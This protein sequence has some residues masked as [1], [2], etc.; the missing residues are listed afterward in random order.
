MSAPVWSI[1]CRRSARRGRSRRGCAD[2]RPRRGRRAPG[3]ATVSCLGAGDL[4]RREALLF[5]CAMR[6]IAGLLVRLSMARTSIT[7]DTSRPRHPLGRMSQKTRSAIIGLG[8]WG[9]KVAQELSAA[10]DLVAFA[11]RTA[12]SG[13]LWAAEH[14]PGA[15]RATVDQIMH[16]NSIQALAIV[17]PIPLLSTLAHSALAAGKH[18]HVE[19]PLAQSSQEAEVLANLAARRGLILSTGYVFLYHPVYSE[20]K[21]RVELNSIRNIKLEWRKFGTFA[22]PIEHSLL[23]HHLALML[24]L[25]GEP[26]AG[27]I[28]HGPGRYTSCDRIETHLEYPAFDAASIIDRTSSRRAHRTTIETDTGSSLV[29]ED[30]VLSSVDKNGTPTMLYDDKRPALAAEIARFAD[31]AAGGDAV[32]PTAGLFA[33]SVLRLQERLRE[34]K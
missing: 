21:R 14:L 1:R 34:V 19:K 24:D 10:T 25:V 18:I 6:C 3:L 15:R 7:L 30:N 13:E 33:A 28:C 8:A 27:T 26:M 32:L 22:E 29:W 2:L 23:T 20:L 16:D 9:K 17:V 12:S 5:R 31:A 11:T 4:L